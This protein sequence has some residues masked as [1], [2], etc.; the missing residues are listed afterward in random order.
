MAS[1]S[2]GAVLYV[3][4]YGKPLNLF[5]EDSWSAFECLK[6]DLMW[7]EVGKEH[8]EIHTIIWGKYILDK[9]SRKHKACAFG[10]L[11]ERKKSHG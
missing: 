5:C 11:R 3:G 10:Y 9:G 4:S 2:V 8:E 6:F 7:L 1:T